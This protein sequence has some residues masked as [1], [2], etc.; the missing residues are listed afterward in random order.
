MYGNS[1]NIGNGG[2]VAK[3]GNNNVFSDFNRLWFMNS[4]S[5]FIYYSDGASHF[6][7]KYNESIPKG[8]VILQ[9]PCTNVTLDGDRL[10]YIN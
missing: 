5:E 1:R 8:S 7:C 2:L 9:K 6:L 4:D 10:L 3:L